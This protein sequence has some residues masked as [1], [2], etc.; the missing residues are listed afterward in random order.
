[1]DQDKIEAKGITLFKKIGLYKLIGYPTF[2]LKFFNLKFLWVYF[3]KLNIPDIIVYF[4]NN[5][6]V[7][8]FSCFMSWGIFVEVKKE[9]IKPSYIEIFL[10]ILVNLILVYFIMKI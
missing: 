4:Q 1:M 6:Y 8:K 2:L 9:S 5:T 10:K 3:P 7:I